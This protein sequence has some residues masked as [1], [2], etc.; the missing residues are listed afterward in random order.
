MYFYTQSLS[1]MH[2]PPKHVRF[3]LSVYLSV[4][5]YFLLKKNSRFLFASQIIIRFSFYFMRSFRSKLKRPFLS[6]VLRCHSFSQQ[7]S[8]QDQKKRKKNIQMKKITQKTKQFRPIIAF[9][10]VF[11]LQKRTT[12]THRSAT[13]KRLTIARFCPT[14][15]PFNSFVCFAINF[16]FT[17]VSFTYISILDLPI[18]FSRFERKEPLEKRDGTTSRTEKS[19]KKK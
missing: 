15:M 16:S 8:R 6:Y 19:D 11:F 7:I 1:H 18:D 10:V 14:K 13:T 4:W 5:I 9:W 2:Q 3:L 17:I 12:H